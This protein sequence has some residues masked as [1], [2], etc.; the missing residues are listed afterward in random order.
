MQL[1]FSDDPVK[2]FKQLRVFHFALAA[3]VP[4]MVYA[5]EIT[6]SQNDAPI[7]DLEGFAWALR[8]FLA[9]HAFQIVILMVWINERRLV[10]KGMKVEPRKPDLV[11]KNAMEATQ[12]MRSALSL[13]PA[14][15]GMLLFMLSGE[16]L[17]LYVP[18]SASVLLL[19]LTRVTRKHWEETYAMASRE[20]PGVSPSPWT[21]A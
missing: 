7:V 15:L 3:A 18:V 9:G 6:V 19:T 5:A 10:A 21:T 20:Y 13:A 4:I 1:E 12:V 2:A 11:V 8:L 14:T 16:R 17:D